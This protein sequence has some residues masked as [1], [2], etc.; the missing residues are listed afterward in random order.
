MGTGAHQQLATGVMTSIFNRPKICIIGAGN[1]ATHLSVALNNVADIVQIYSHNLSN[2]TFLANKIGKHGIE[3]DNLADIRSGA[4]FYIVSVKDDVIGQVAHD[5]PDSGIW[6]HTSGSIPMDIFNGLKS[7]K[8]VFY[9][10][11][12]FS[13]DVDLD[14]RVVPLFIE[15][16]DPSTQRELTKLGNLITDRVTPADSRRRKAL[17]I[18]AVFACNF[19]N[20]MWTQADELLKREGLD[21]GYL[22]PL[23]QETLRKIEY[24]SPEDAQTGPARRGDKHI[25]ESHLKQISD[26]GQQAIYKLLSEQILEHYEQNKL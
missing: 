7:R 10:L 26:P 6:A 5:T 1:V 17:H 11:Q 23:L 13:K 9:P 15:A 20:Y 2:A 4:D 19:V 22:S 21:I 16:G 14:M 18:A 25:I 3:T 8:G 12:T 24:T